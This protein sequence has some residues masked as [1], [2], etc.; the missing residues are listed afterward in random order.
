[1]QMQEEQ[2]K[3]NRPDVRLTG[4]NQTEMNRME[5]RQAAAGQ[6]E[7]KRIKRNQAGESLTETVTGTGLSGSTLKIIAVLSMI[8]DHWCYLFAEHSTEV[9]E[10]GR[11]WI[12]R[13]AFPIFCFLLAEG[14]QKTGNRKKYGQ[15]L[16][17]FAF[18]SEIPFDLFRYGKVFSVEGCNIFV[19]LFL[20]FLLMAATEYVTKREMSEI[21]KAFSRLPAL[22]FTVGAAYL[23]HSDYSFYGVISIYIFY[24]FRYQKRQ[25]LMM[26]ALS[27]LYEPT[28]LTAFVPI[29]FYNGR[30][31]LKSKYFFY[32][33]YPVHLLVLYLAAQLLY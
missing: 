24:M 22:L 28:A 33:F 4:M 30:R 12:G 32:L 5:I 7:E 18:L 1:M 8:V 21:R 13:V 25:Q 31:G 20:G 16:L 2:T 6:T 26:G 17:L 23:I 3:M 14:F 11:M 9:Y 19:T 29:A 15:R 10:I 27:F